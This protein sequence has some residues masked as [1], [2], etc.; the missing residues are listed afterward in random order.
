MFHFVNSFSTGCGSPGALEASYADEFP[1][2]NVYPSTSWRELDS[3]ISD[4]KNK[5]ICSSAVVDGTMNEPPGS[6]VIEKVLVDSEKVPGS[7]DECAASAT[8]TKDYGTDDEW[9]VTHMSDAQLSAMET[10]H[11]IANTNNYARGPPK[12][13][14]ADIKCSILIRQTLE[15]QALLTHDAFM[16]A[17]IEH[18]EKLLH[19]QGT[20]TPSSLRGEILKQHVEDYTKN[21]KELSDRLIRNLHTRFNDEQNIIEDCAR[22]IHAIELQKFAYMKYLSEDVLTALEKKLR[23]HSR[24]LYFVQLEILEEKQ[25]MFSTQQQYQKILADYRHLVRGVDSVEEEDEMK[26]MI[27]KERQV[28]YAAIEKS[29]DKRDK[30]LSER[31]AAFTATLQQTQS[32]NKERECLMGQIERLGI[33]IES[34]EDQKV[35]VLDER[36]SIEEER[37]ISERQQR[38]QECQI[39]ELRDEVQLLRKKCSEFAEEI[40]ALKDE[41]E[42]QQRGKNNLLRERQFLY[43]TRV[44]ADD[45]IALLNVNLEMIR[46]RNASLESSLNVNR[47]DLNNFK[48]ELATAHETIAKLQQENAEYQVT[49]NTVETYKMLIDEQ[50]RDLTQMIAAEDNYLQQIETLS[51]ENREYREKIERLRNQQ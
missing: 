37:A 3:S 22:T 51:N 15:Q 18:L 49:A 13:S 26:A 5:S 1:T 10:D 8:V 23:S 19:K 9:V 20:V 44:H 42:M 47:E 45:Q 30:E 46:E 7:H 27:D 21:M 11:V 38:T 43:E 36:Q 31:E 24:K 2:S 28:K 35:R 4:E 17:R 6:C 41:N 32:L 33:M 48:A 39:T 16:K 34:L 40:D 50:E 12:L 14:E 25:S 29:L